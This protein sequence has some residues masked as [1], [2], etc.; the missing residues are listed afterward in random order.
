MILLSISPMQNLF[1]NIIDAARIG[2]AIWIKI[3]IY[4]HQSQEL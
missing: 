1:W 3:Y 4:N 2:F